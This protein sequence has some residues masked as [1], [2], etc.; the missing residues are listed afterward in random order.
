MV[1][2]SLL[3]SVFGIV[4][5]VSYTGHTSDLYYNRGIHYDRVVVHQVLDPE[6]GNIL[7]RYELSPERYH[8]KT[9]KYVRVQYNEKKYLFRSM[10]R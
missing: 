2:W 8:Q 6:Y 10:S 1:W 7:V 3:F 4:S 9:S 5:T